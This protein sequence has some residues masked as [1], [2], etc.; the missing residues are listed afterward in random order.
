MKQILLTQGKVALVDD[1]DFERVNQYKWQYSPAGKGY[2][3]RGKQIKLGFWKY[4]VITIL[5]HRYIMGV[6]NEPRGVEIDH[7]NR[8]PL[9]NRKANLRVCDRSINM[10]NRLPYKHK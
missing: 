7:I 2:A 8:N 10:R 1:E 3:K 5:M 4:K 9:D 6:E